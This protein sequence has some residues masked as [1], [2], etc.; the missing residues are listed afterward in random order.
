MTDYEYYSYNMD[1][2]GYH[3]DYETD[4]DTT[5]G[6]TEYSCHINPEEELTL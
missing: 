4:Y 3:A 2:L 1:A 5:D 6:E